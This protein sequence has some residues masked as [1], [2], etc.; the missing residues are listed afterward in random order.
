MARPHELRTH[1]QAYHRKFRN[2]HMRGEWFE[3]CPEIE[4]E[5]ERL[6]V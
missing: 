5:I 2:H 4:A 6:R 1:E 3:R